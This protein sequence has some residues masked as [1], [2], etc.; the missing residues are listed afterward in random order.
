[1]FCVSEP[2]TGAIPCPTNLIPTRSA[3][4]RR[5]FWKEY[6][7]TTAQGLGS[8]AWRVVIGRRVM[9]LIVRSFCP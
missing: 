4:E 6:V 7:V 2:A 1:L 8:F 9:Y 5:E 3:R